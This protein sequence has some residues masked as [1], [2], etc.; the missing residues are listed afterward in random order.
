MVEA[1]WVAIVICGS[2]LIYVW[3]THPSEKDGI[4]P[5]QRLRLRY[6][7]S[8][9]R[10]PDDE[11]EPV[12]D[13]TGSAG[14]YQQMTDTDAVRASS[15]QRTGTSRISNRMSDSELLALLAIQRGDNNEY[16]FSANQI[17][18]F[19]GGTRTVVLAQVRAIRN[20]PQPV[21]YPELTPEQ[22]Q[23]RE[24]LGLPRR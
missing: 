11:R 8:S 18:S 23:A 12:D 13:E 24:E 9:R 5:W 2:W 10:G 6:I 22:I 1:F 17:A 15:A 21:H 16:R 14:S 4:T 19:I 20:T 7:P 3:F